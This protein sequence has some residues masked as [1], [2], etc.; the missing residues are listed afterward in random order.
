[1]KVRAIET[2]QDGLD[3]EHL[4]TLH[5]EEFGG[6]REFSSDAVSRACFKCVVD[7]E[8]KY[9][10]CW[11]C[12]DDHNLP[13]GYLSGAMY[14]S[15]YSDRFYAI[16]EMWFVIPRVRG[17]RAAILLLNAYEHW[18][19]GRQAERIYTQV[20]HDG[21]L[22]TTEYVFDLLQRLGY[23]KQGYI[24]VKTEDKYNYDRT[25]HRAVGAEA[26]H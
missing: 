20:E 1:M 4:A 17:S 9:L 13:V 12:Y 2:P 19:K 16:Q 26:Q 22:S 24:A 18:A 5:H 10:N 23:R 21:D 14:P 15:T 25:T 11:V 6:T 8:R 3:V 7:K